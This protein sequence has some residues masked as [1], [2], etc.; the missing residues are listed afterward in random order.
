VI[1]AKGNSLLE[2]VSRLNLR[3]H[4]LISGGTGFFGKALL[5]HLL[6]D[7]HQESGHTESSAKKVPAPISKVTIISRNP[8]AFLTQ[9]PEF[10]D[11]SSVQWIR[12]DLTTNDVNLI[13]VIE[14][15]TAAQNGFTHIL[16]AA[17]ESTRG[18]EL[19]HSSQFHQITQGT[20]N[21]L[22]VAKH[23]KAERF[24]LTSSGGAYGAMPSNLSAFPESHLGMPNPLD[25]R[26]AYGLGKR[27]SE[28]LCTLAANDTGLEVV[29]TRPFAFCGPDLP[30]DVHFAIGNFIRDALSKDEITVQGDG[31]P[32]R[33]YLDQDDL[34]H[35]LL[36]MLFHGKPGEAYNLGSDEGI[37]IGDLAHKVR[38]LLAPNK[39][40][41]IRGPPNSTSPRQVYV[42]DIRKAKE[43]LGLTP[44]VSL[45]DSIL[46]TARAHS[47]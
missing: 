46:R 11:L 27:V 6:N 19:S 34:A 28:Y 44:T 38:D 12:A 29:I 37:S 5:R 47:L 36:T 16:H 24:L 21:M 31:S 2:S 10:R 7:H 23:F 30:L 15:S 40:V 20:R 41:V 3:S 42:P 14:Q 13:E 17:T 39:R 35:W 43:E 1:S 25:P 45:N 8:E 26:S 33:S 9:H 18:A 32:I 4:I 22:A